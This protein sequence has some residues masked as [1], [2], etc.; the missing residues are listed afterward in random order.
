MIYALPRRLRACL[1][2][3]VRSFILIFTTESPYIVSTHAVVETSAYLKDA[4]DAGIPDADR[5]AIKFFLSKNPKAG[6]L[7]EGTG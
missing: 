3:D 5:A 6:D 7:M 1:L 4:D 2:R